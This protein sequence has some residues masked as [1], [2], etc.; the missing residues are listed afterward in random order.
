M[1]RPAEILKKAQREIWH[2]LPVT[3][4]IN[5][6]TRAGIEFLKKAI[7]HFEASEPNG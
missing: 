4:H 6:N 7:E 5:E 2:L 1:D 3:D